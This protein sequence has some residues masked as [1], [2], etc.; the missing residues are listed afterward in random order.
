MA[1]IFI[2]WGK[3]DDKQVR[4]LI[5]HLR[6]A[7]FSIFEY[8]DDMRA[9]DQITTRVLREINSAKVCILCLSDLTV[10]RDWIRKELNYAF[11]AFHQRMLPMRAIMP[12]Q[13]GS[14]DRTR[15]PREIHDYDLFIEDLSSAVNQR[16]GIAN[17]TESISMYLGRPS[18]LIIPTTII[19]MSR[20]QCS[21]LLQTE[22]WKHHATLCETYGMVWT[23]EAILKRYGETAFDFRAFLEEKLLRQHLNDVVDRINKTRSIFADP[24]GRDH[25]AN[26]ILTYYSAEALTGSEPHHPEIQQHWQSS[27]HLIIVDSLSLCHR[28]IRRLFTDILATDGGPEAR[29]IALIPAFTFHTASIPHLIRGTTSEFFPLS[30]LLDD[31]CSMPECSVVFDTST[32][33]ALKRWCVEALRGLLAPPRAILKNVN[34]MKSLQPSQMKS[35]RILGRSAPG[36][37][38][39]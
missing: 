4:P 34:L 5:S 31:W 6:S 36:T 22:S 38:S 9:G 16:R 35:P 28:D 7:K 26:I 10:D 15:S 3:P 29:S 32:E 23:D 14:L 12:I 39:S 25:G 24:K 11:S 21:A 19:A 18:P 30:K 27:R 20:A 17:L 37:I 1:D 8:S 2:S 13:V 33:P